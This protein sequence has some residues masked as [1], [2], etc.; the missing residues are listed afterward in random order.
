MR[1]RLTPSRE[2]SLMGATAGDTPAIGPRWRAIFAL[3]TVL[4]QADWQAAEGVLDHA[5][6]WAFDRP[7]SSDAF[8]ARFQA[9]LRDAWDVKLLPTALLYEVPRGEAHAI[10]LT[11][12]LM[13]A[14]VDTWEE[15]EVLFDLHVGEA[16]ERVVFVGLLP[17]TP[18]FVPFPEDGEDD[19]GDEEAPPM[20][21]EGPTA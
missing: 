10:G 7:L 16:D 5:W 1:V 9:L 11:C 13:W 19:D 12:C 15:R 18:E 17:P 14:E 3:K 6:L 8:I 2:L 21:A 20:Q 4:E